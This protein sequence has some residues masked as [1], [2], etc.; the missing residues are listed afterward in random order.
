MVLVPH[1]APIQ[2]VSD[3]TLA[4]RKEALFALQNVSG[5]PQGRQSE[6]QY[7]SGTRRR[8]CVRQTGGGKSWK[9]ETDTF[10]SVDARQFFAILVAVLARHQ[11]LPMS[12]CRTWLA[13]G[14]AR[15]RR[16]G[17]SGRKSVDDKRTPSGGRNHRLAAARSRSAGAIPLCRCRQVAHPAR[18]GPVMPSSMRATG[19]ECFRSAVGCQPRISHSQPFLHSRSSL[20]KQVTR[21]LMKRQS[22]TARLSQHQ[23]DGAVRMDA[24]VHIFT[25]AHRVRLFS[26]A[27]PPLLQRSRALFTPCCART[28]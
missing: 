24:C 15:L 4:G 18:I 20:P 1:V 6:H 27:G 12:A 5:R 9:C 25:G 11:Y 10:G 17:P 16:V 13:P 28:R 21:R 3:K 7:F 14:S 2:L 23:Q 8:S 19:A 26:S 22:L